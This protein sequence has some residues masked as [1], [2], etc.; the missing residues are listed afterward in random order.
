MKY[1]LF[2]GSLRTESLNKKLVRV[3][4]S[5]LNENAANEVIVTEL[6]DL[7][8]P[9]YDGDIEA[10]GIPDGVKTLGQ[11][12]RST[13]ALVISTPEYNGSIA[14]PLKNAVDW[15]SRLR[16]N[17]FER[18]PV[19]LL[20][21]SPGALGAVRGLGATRAPF[22]TLGAFVFPTVFG[23]AKA[24]EAF[25]PTGELSNGDTHKRVKELLAN[26]ETFAMR[27]TRGS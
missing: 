17:P 2:S 15:A 27:L 9:I 18:K 22:E 8:L 11:L 12:I 6:R 21:A 1:L 14:S 16:P 7:A 25:T 24:D 10:T 13:Q 26:F 23:L 5:M 20:G 4:Q 19:L 3:V